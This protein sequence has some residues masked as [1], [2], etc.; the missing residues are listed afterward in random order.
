MTFA[1]AKAEFDRTLYKIKPKGKRTLELEIFPLNT[2]DEIIWTSSNPKIAKVNSQG[3]ITGIRK[4]TVTITARGVNTGFVASCQLKVCNV[5]QIA[6]TFDDGPGKYTAELLDFLK[7][8]DIRVTFFLV[9]NRMSWYKNTLKQ[10]VNDGHEIGYHSWKHDIQT[11]LPNSKIIS[12][13]Q[14]SA[15]LLK[16][17]TGAE[18]TLWRAPG[19]GRSDRVL[20]QIDLPHIM[21]SVDTLDWKYRKSTRTCNVI[22][23]YSKDGSIVLLH[24]IHKSTVEGAMNALK[25]MQEGDYEFLTVTELLSRNGQ[26]PQ[27][28]KTYF[29]G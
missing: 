25:Q 27:N 11:T 16:K 28:H 13:Y 8:N 9:G 7:E 18:F 17:I 4:G 21:W 2:K 20:K 3:V 23:K 14:K 10:M 12:D 15:K 19:G 24:D 6:I 29:K 22:K 5:K 1:I 26:K